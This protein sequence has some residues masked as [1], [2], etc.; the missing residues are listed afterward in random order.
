MKQMK[1]RSQKHED[2]FHCFKRIFSVTS[3]VHAPISSWV[4][5][6]CQIALKNQAKAS[7]IASEPKTEN[8][9]NMCF[10]FYL[11]NVYM[12]HHRKHKTHRL[13]KTTLKLYEQSIPETVQVR[14]HGNTSLVY[15]KLNPS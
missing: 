1:P 10:F 15:V 4:A 3:Y 5:L 9:R 12:D 6:C 8:N 11:W 7:A 14:G 2:E 13:H